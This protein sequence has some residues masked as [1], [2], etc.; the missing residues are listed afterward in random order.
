MQVDNHKPIV[1]DKYK[2]ESLFCQTALFQFIT[3]MS[4]ETKEWLTI[5][6]GSVNCLF[7]EGTSVNKKLTQSCS[8]LNVKCTHRVHVWWR[9]Q[10]KVHQFK[11]VIIITDTLYNINGYYRR[12]G[13][14]ISSEHQY[15]A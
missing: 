9:F 11:H 10:K 3:F 5:I 7:N 1:S 13:I 6:I 4:F 12:L 14:V 8:I 2:K 15:I